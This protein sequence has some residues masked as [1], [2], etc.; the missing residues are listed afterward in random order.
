MATTPRSPRDRLAQVLQW[1]ILDVVVTMVVAGGFYWLALRSDHQQA[2]LNAQQVALN[3]Q[4]AAAA[5]WDHLL[6]LSVT[7]RTPR[8]ILLADAR[9]CA[10][11]T[12]P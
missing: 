7:T 3:H 5:C 8:A 10:K 1:V 2:R 9:L 6:K 4:A 12:D 11:V